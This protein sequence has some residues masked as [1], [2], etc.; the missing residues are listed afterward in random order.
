MSTGRS[1]LIGDQEWRTLLDL[2]QLALIPKS[3]RPLSEQ[4]PQESR[5]LWDPV[6]QALLAKQWQNATNQKQTIEQKQR[7]IAS[8]RKV[9]NDE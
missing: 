6:T 5:R 4:D 7:D 1:R 3:V 2:D 9:A 8:K